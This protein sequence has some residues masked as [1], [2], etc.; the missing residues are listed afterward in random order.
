MKKIILSAASLA[1]AAVASV[2]VAPTTSEAIPAFARQTG[3][4]CLACHFQSF[5]TLNAYGRSFKMGGLT[6]VGDQALVEDEHLSIPAVVNWTAMVRPQFQSQDTGGTKVDSIGFADQVLMIGG[7]AGEHTGVFIE[8]AAGDVATG[9]TVDTTVASTTATVSDGGG[10][11]A[12]VQMYNS[13]DMGDMK[14]GATIWADGFGEDSGMQLMSVWGQHGGLLGG[15]ALTINGAMA[16]DAGGVGVTGWAGNETWNAQLA[17]VDIAGIGGFT[18]APVLRGN[19]FLDAGDW[20]VGLG[21]IAVTGSQN[22]IDTQRTGIDV[23][24]FGE[25]NDMQIGVFADYATAP[26]STSNVYATAN[27]DRTG[28]SFRA[29]VKPTHNLIFLAGIGQDKA[30]VTI[31]KT[32]VGVEWE[33]YQNFAVSL[34]Y[35]EEKTTGAT[36]AQATTTKTTLLDFELLI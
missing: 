26:K 11:Y 2:S 12:N 17:M 22:N 35:N 36:A 28:Y 19:Y 9:Q 31:D 10:P 15:K 33:A 20:E 8:F 5:P 16:G 4:A 21:A 1:V 13:W 25:V 30:D 32:L 3:S 6:D 18:L 24:A 23:Q 14:V 7:R 27:N 34:S 29:S